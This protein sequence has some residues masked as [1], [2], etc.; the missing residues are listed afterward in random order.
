[1]P[2]VY[3]NGQKIFYETYGEGQP[4]L[5]MHGWMQVGH[6]LLAIADHLADAYRIILPDM[7]GYG[8]SVPP[9]RA[10]PPD[11]Y[12][13][14]TTLMTGFLDTLQLSN[15]HIVGHSDGGEVALL[16]PI[17][18]PDLC[19][20]VSAWG[21]VGGFDQELCDHVR[22][23]MLPMRIKD[24]QRARHP[25]QNVDAWPAQ[26]VEAF[27]AIIAAGGDVSLSRADQI[28][29]PLLLMLGDQDSLNPVAAG[30]RFIAAASRTGS[31]GTPGQLEV[32]VGAGHPIHD[33]QPGQF[34]KTL[35]SFLQSVP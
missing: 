31:N 12:Q 17:L 34:L 16:M 23:S 25:G 22:E 19:R 11:F 21:S 7:P 1:M 20:S 29:C 3:V 10:F 4:L 5:L 15:V 24:N 18:R 2:S 35:R 13:R 26:W 6:D 9:Y 28:R 33:Q 14:D 30:K 8:R 27:C 32:F